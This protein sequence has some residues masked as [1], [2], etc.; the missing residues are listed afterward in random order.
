MHLNIS[1]NPAFCHPERSETEAKDLRT[2]FTVY[3]IQMRGFFDC[4]QR[5]SLR[6]TELVEQCINLPYYN[7]SNR[8]KTLP[9][10]AFIGRVGFYSVIARR[11]SSVRGA[12]YSFHWK[13]SAYFVPSGRSSG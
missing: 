2:G 3:V 12:P 1:N 11:R 8:R 10:I 13:D 7:L 5:A 4:A 9:M 6:M